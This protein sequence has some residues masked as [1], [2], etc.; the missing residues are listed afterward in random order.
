MI[1]V[2]N[3]HDNCL[4]AAAHYVIIRYNEIRSTED[5]GY[6]DGISGRSNFSFQGSLNRDSDI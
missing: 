2:F 4:D 3:L 5:H 6:N 1:D